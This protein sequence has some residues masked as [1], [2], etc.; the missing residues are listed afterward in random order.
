[1]HIAPVV[2]CLDNCAANSVTDHVPVHAITAAVTLFTVN[3]TILFAQVR[4]SHKAVPVW[5]N[6]KS[7]SVY[8]QELIKYTMIS[9]A[10]TSREAIIPIYSLFVRLYIQYHMQFCVTVITFVRKLL[11]F[12]CL[13][14]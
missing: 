4:C 12:S 11:V 5:S 3:N 1:M 8:S 13:R 7:K 6:Y 14:D 2:S 9:K 10:S